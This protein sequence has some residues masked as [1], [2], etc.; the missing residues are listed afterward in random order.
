MTSGIFL[1]RRAGLP[2]LFYNL[3][4]AL[5]LAALS[6]EHPPVRPADAASPVLIWDI[7]PAKA[8]AL[9]RNFRTTDDLPRSETDESFDNV[10]LKELRASGSGEFTADNFK[11]V[12]ARTRG[13]VTV[14]DLRQETHIFINGLPASWFATHD[15][16]NVGRSRAAIEAEEAARV[17]SLK[18]GIEISIQ[19]GELVKKGRRDA[20]APQRVTV[21]NANTERE[22]VEAA[23]ARYVR[24]PVTDHARPMDEEVDRFILAVREMPPDGWA[25]FHCEAGRGRTTTFMALYDMLRNAARISLEAIA[26]RQKLL[27]YGYDVL[28]PGVPGNWKAPYIADRIAFVRAFYDYA[29]ANPN[30]R[31]QLWSEWLKS[32]AQ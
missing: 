8:S 15:W 12:L 19:S 27:G 29:R 24:I 32:G 31:P 3:V 7:D 6:P 5:C 9:P 2:A 1:F 16:A 30:G 20:G 13:P 26:R 17:Q 11:L 22:L 10:G 28:A 25:H 4:G 23:G 14:F 18:P 21:D